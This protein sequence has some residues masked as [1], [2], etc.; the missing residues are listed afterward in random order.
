MTE[1]YII[2][3]VFITL[4]GASS[5]YYQVFRLIQLDAKCRGFKHPTFWGLFFAGGNNGGSGVLLYLLGRK[6]YPSV[7]T[8]E[9]HS[10][11][12]SRK[13]RAG[14]SLCF[15]AAGSISLVIACLFNGF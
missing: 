14:V 7:M 15:L 11:M 2:I 12:E 4:L 13:R 5:L 8:E 9:Q 1:W 10:L 6:K 3:L